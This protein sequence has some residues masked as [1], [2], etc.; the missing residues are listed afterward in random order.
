MARILIIVACL[1]GSGAPLFSQAQNTPAPEPRQQLPQP[2]Q[3]RQ[4][5]FEPIP[6]A[7]VPAVGP[8]L[9]EGVD[10]RGSRRS[11]QDALREGIFSKVGDPYNE[12]TVRRDVMILRNTNRFDEVRVSSEE[13]KKGGVI[14]HFVVTD[15]PPTQ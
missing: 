6:A 12:H 7:R 3:N 14:L 10:F 13:G 2:V 9:I 4:N 15:R 5:P 1:C 11:P 8:G